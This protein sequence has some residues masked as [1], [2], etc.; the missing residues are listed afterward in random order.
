MTNTAHILGAFWETPERGVAILKRDWIDDEAMPPLV[1]GDGS[2]M[3]L[4]RRANPL[5]CACN[6]GFCFVGDKVA[7][8]LCP[9]FFQNL[10]WEHEAIYVAGDF[11]GWEKAVG[12]EPWRMRT[13]IHDGQPLLVLRVPKTE[14]MRSPKPQFKFVTGEGAWVEVPRRAP[15]AVSNGQNR[16]FEIRTDRTGKN[17]FLFWPQKQ[18]HRVRDLEF[19]CWKDPKDSQRCQIKEGYLFLTRKDDGRLGAFIQNGNT[20]FRVF[21]PRAEKVTAHFRPK[22][23][24]QGGRALELTR[25]ANGVWEGSVEGDLDGWFYYYS[26]EGQNRDDTTLFDPNVKVMDPWAR[27]V[28]GPESLGIVVR[29]DRFEHKQRTSFH[30]PAWQDLVIAECHVR[31]VLRHAPFPLTDS[32]RKGFA[33]LTEC[34]KHPD[35]YL[36]RLGVNAVELQPVQENDAPNPDAYHWGYMTTNFFSPASMYAGDPEHASQIEEFRELVEAFHRAGIAVILDVVYNHAGEP[37]HLLRLDKAYYFR[38]EFGQ[39]L[40]NWSGCGNDL[41]TYAPMAK[42]LI[43]ESLVHLVKAYNVDGFRFDLADLVGVAVLK[44]IEKALKQVKPSIVLIAEPWSFRGHI[45]HALR[46][47]GFASWNDGY[48]EF[49]YKYVLGQGNRDGLKYFLGGSYGNF[50][51]WP[52]QTVNYTASHDDYCWIDK[53]TENKNHDGLW[54]TATDQ[55]RTRLMF[56]ILFMS[57]GMPM[58]AQGQDFMHSK[59][60]VH[61][62]YQDPDRNALDYNRACDYSDTA[63]YARAWIRFR[64]TEGRKWLCLFSPPSQNY[65]Q[66][67]ENTDSSALGV[68]YNADCSHGKKRLFFAVNP[69]PWT[70]ALP[71]DGLNPDQFTQLADHNGF[72]PEGCMNPAFLWH[73]DRL[74]LPPFSCALF[75]DG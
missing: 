8:V 17:M 56:A 3:K 2:P 23:R 10:D 27:A 73:D 54:P 31:D 5:F 32:Q 71:T 12:H 34:L 65:F 11:N 4:I 16:N 63:A 42:R 45:A 62:T 69:H 55:R 58:I 33:G 61:N 47:T 25:N 50:A 41:R 66:F 15:N 40:S 13:E 26:V 20:H 48:R 72:Y 49:V 67:L 29:D 39:G 44:E 21:A 36:R 38:S 43:I 46:H 7:F 24:E 19:V 30:P 70:Q 51:R 28:I 57:L 22:R 53:I 60:G 68:L 6:A 1:M 18:P 9:P 37:N 59:R 64:T 75:A 35:F 52:A 74:Q 14:V